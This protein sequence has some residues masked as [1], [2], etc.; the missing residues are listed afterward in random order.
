MVE[1]QTEE[2]EAAKRACFWKKLIISQKS[3]KRN[4][5]TREGSS[6][7]YSSPS[8][9]SYSHAY[10][11]WMRICLTSH[12]THYY[13]HIDRAAERV[14]DFLTSSLTVQHSP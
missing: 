1:E 11:Y 8:D 13:T 4:F 9:V 6:Y 5:A 3:P 2:E 7:V 10:C 14:A 12:I